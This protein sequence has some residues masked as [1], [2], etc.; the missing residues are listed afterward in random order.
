MRLRPVTLGLLGAL[1]CATPA[2]PPSAAQA[3]VQALE[4]GHLDTAYALTAPAFR[5]Q[6]SPAAFQARFADP[7]ARAARAAAVRTGLAE[8]ERS[9]PELYGQVATEAP[10]AVILQF[11]AAVRA[12]RFEEARSCLAAPLR[13]RYSP[14]LLAEDFAAEPGATARLGRATLAAE[15]VPIQ[16]GD[17]VRF[18]LGNGG[19][20]VVVREA[21]GWRLLA[22]E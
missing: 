21:D 6:V 18:P 16:Q 2:P 7:A 4:A 10:E 15:G 14:A 17:Q 5:A 9:A 13:S 8:L 1:A 11:A 12:G 20:V 19:A 22:L 3:Y